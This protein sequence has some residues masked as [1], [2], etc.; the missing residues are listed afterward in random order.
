M[1]KLNFLLCQ[2]EFFFYHGQQ[3]SYFFRS[4]RGLRQG[5]LLSPYLFIMVFYVLNK[6]ISKAKVSY[7]SGFVVGSGSVFI[8]HLQFADN[9]MIFC[10]ADM[11]QIGYLRCILCVFVMVT[12][13]PINLARSKMFGVRG[14]VQDLDSLAWILGCK[15]GTLPSTQ[16]GMLL[17]A[18]SKSKVIWNPV[19]ERVEV[20]EGLLSKGG[21][22]TLIKVVLAS[23][24]NYFP[25]LFSVLA[26]V[27]NQIE[28]LMQNFLWNDSLEHHHYHLVD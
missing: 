15:I 19:I 3:V 5:D 26:L 24:S 11:R 14:D 22:L 17:G 21:R 28:R 4:F 9:T 13:L 23:I 20:L 16:L 27:A 2:I 18:H 1:E 10:D 12:G 7:I 6:M 8:F 25:S